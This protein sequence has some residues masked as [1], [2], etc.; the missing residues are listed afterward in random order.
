MELR[1]AVRQ[2]H[3]AQERQHL[4]L[5]LERVLLV[6]LRRP[7]EVAQ[8]HVAK[9]SDARQLRRADSF[10]LGEVQQACHGL[11]ACPKN[12]RVGLTA[13]LIVQQ[14]RLHPTSW[15]ILSRNAVRA[16]R[17]PSGWPR[18]SALASLTVCSGLI[19][20]GSGGS[21]GSTTASRSAGFGD[22]RNCSMT[23]LAC[24]GSSSV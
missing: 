7:V 19:L 15:V 11:I 5:A 20:P 3:V 1:R 18:R 9:G 12:H 22:A 6:L 2:G 8:H 10:S 13:L 4:H 24:R 23:L 14:L 21:Q 17:G 16:M